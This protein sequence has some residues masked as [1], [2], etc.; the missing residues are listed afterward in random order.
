MLVSRSHLDDAT[1]A[2]VERLQEPERVR[3]GS[4]LKF[5]LIAEGSADL[6]PRLAP[7]SAWDVAAGQAVL[8]AAGGGVQTP[9][10]NTLRYGPGGFLIPAFIAFGDRTAGAPR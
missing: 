6:Y 2:Y 8:T 7:T 3:C 1:V 9:D 4:A 5:G 10:G